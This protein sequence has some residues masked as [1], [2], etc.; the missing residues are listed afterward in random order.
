MG[1]GGRTMK[2]SSGPVVKFGSIIK[3]RRKAK[4]MTQTDLADE[5]GVI[6]NTV[7]NWEADKAKP[8]F[9]SIPKLCSI[10]GISTEDL[11]GAHG[12]DTY[13]EEEKKLVRNYRALSMLGQQ[14][15]QKS[16][17]GMLQAELEAEGQKICR[18]FDPIVEVLGAYAAGLDEPYSDDKDDAIFIRKTP[19]SIRADFIAHVKGRSM[20]PDYHDG[21]LVYCRSSSVAR[22]GQD[23]VC[24]T[25]E[26]RL[27]KRI[28]EDGMLFS[29]NPDP[30][31]KLRKMYE[32]DD[33]NI[34]GIVIGIV[35]RSDF[36]SQRELITLNDL[37]HDDMKEFKEENQ[38]FDEW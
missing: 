8:E 16:V 18:S 1:E 9:D 17:F 10:L 21:D 19:I 38:I 7:V 28:G 11:F 37:R 22:P 25:S 6:R 30:F 14:M 33:V 34:R 12:A 24:T 20:E 4:G 29:V 27:I 15:A 35:K 26:G 2:D 36:P 5:M 31:Y 32:D 13:S 3:E 23:V